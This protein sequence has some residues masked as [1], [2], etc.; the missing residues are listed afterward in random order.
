[1]EEIKKQND[2]E[3]EVLIRPVSKLSDLK[4]RDLVKYRHILWRMVYRDIRLQ[5]D[6]LAL[7]FFWSAALPLTMML[8]FMFLKRFSRANMYETVPYSIYAYSGLILWFN[9]REVCAKVMYSVGKESGLIK[10]VYFPRLYLPLI[11][12][13]SSYYNLALA[14][15]PLGIMMVITR[16]YPGFR[17]I[18]LPLVMIQYSMLTFGIGTIFTTLSL[19]KKDFERTL[20]LILY[21]GLFI[22]P[23]IY[24]PDM[25]PV[26]LRTIYLL[27]PMAGTLLAFRSC[28][29]NDFPFPFWEFGYSCVVSVIFLVVGTIMFKK[30]EIYFADKL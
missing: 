9:F 3:E 27:N 15:V 23:V 30:S 18:L 12:V 17:L 2:M 16:L 28:L 11:P 4:L 13:F 21:V 22:S 29:F 10:K 7:G 24:A 19:I 26:K 20:L 14:A 6:D 1:M 5:Y 25:I 8:T